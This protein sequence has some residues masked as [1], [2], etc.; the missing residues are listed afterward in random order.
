MGFCF[1]SLLSSRLF[2]KAIPSD[3][4][5]WPIKS[6]VEIKRHSLSARARG[7]AR[8]GYVTGYSRSMQVDTF[9]IDT[10]MGL[11]C[12]G[13]TM[14][15]GG[16]LFPRGLVFCPRQQRNCGHLCT[17]RITSYKAGILITGHW[18]GRLSLAPL[19]RPTLLG[20]ACMC[21]AKKSVLLGLTLSM[22]PKYGAA[23][24]MSQLSMSCCGRRSV[25]SIINLVSVP[26][27]AVLYL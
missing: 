11:R 15:F 26:F 10:D 27:H 3:E 1:L 22:V 5:P 23:A 6:C 21:Q 4:G 13:E 2:A 17:Y 20:W 14:R 8:G 16:G 7:W 18:N 9:M 25:L 24:L 12:L 19:L